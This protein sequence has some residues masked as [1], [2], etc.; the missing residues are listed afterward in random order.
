M[1]ALQYVDVP[2]YAALLLRDTYTNLSMPGALMDRA[3][4]WLYGSDA[5]WSDKSSTWWFPNGASLTFGHMA[6]PRDHLN[7]KSSEFQ[8]IGVDEASDL[9]WKQI[10][11]MFSRLRR[12]EGSE[13]PLRFRLGSNPGGI[14]HDELKTKYIDPE[15]REQGVVF[16]PAILEDNPYLDKDEYEKGLNKLDPV[17]RLR[18]RKGDWSVRETGRMFDRSWF[19]I[20]DAAPV[21]VVKRVRYWDLAAT[22]AQ[23][24]DER[25]PARTS[26]CRMSRTKDNICYIESIVTTMEKPLMV[27]KLVRQCADMDGKS[28]EI[29]MEQEPGSGG[30]NT[31]DHY[32]RNVLPEFFFK[33]DKVDKSKFTRAQPFSSYAEA[34]NVCLVNG[35]WVKDFLDEIEIFPD[36][37]FK[38]RADSASGAYNSIFGGTVET[39]ARWL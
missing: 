29:W 6:G 16:I 28:V 25:K 13:V 10:N 24:D 17:T 32:R 11:Y 3:E 30:V 5:K 20:V 26:G 9:R 38:D 12:L 8:F 14:S 22:K 23:E 35:P 36:G 19:K 27:Q 39:R 33:P 1:A 31:I 15:T 21:D 37:K 4:D 18:L 34:G 2:H 7:Y